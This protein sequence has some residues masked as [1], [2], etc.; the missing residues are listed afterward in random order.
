MQSQLENAQARELEYEQAS[1][2]AIRDSL[3]GT[4][5]ALSG[6]DFTE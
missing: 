4:G 2:Q 6:V 5:T 3:S 1:S